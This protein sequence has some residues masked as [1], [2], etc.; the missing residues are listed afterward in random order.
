MTIIAKAVQRVLLCL[1]VF[2]SVPLAWAAE[3]PPNILIE[4]VSA[5][6]GMVGDTFAVNFIGQ[7]GMIRAFTSATPAL[8]A[9]VPP[10]DY[11]IIVIRSNDQNLVQLTTTATT[12]PQNLTAELPPMSPDAPRMRLVQLSATGVEPSDGGWFWQFV[13]GD[14]ILGSRQVAEP[15]IKAP[16]PVG[17]YVVRLRR[18]REDRET[19][20]AVDVEIGTGV[21]E[22]EFEWDPRAIK[23]DAVARARIVPRK[24]N[25]ATASDADESPSGDADQPL[26]LIASYD[27]QLSQVIA[28]ITDGASD[29]NGGTIWLTD[30]D[31]P[32]GL[33]VAFID[34][35][36]EARFSTLNISSE[37]LAVEVRDASGLNI[38]ARTIVEDWK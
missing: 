22:A 37:Q 35:R 14:R 36:G 30:G 27:P 7:D 15:T 21:L 12:E 11:T 9:A 24:P 18:G 8:Q 6:D 29:L 33:D 32:G 31:G 5:Q 26:K 2:F 34:Q 20:V 25:E 17:S 28:R 19:R 10:G 1:M 38:R 16:L 13:Q 4:I 3:D 23:D